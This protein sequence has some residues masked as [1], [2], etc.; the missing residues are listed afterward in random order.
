MKKYIL[1][2]LFI[3]L[4]AVTTNVYS[5]D[6]TPVQKAE[7]AL[8]QAK[9][10]EQNQNKAT[11][12]IDNPEKVNQWLDIGTN[13]G[14]ALSGTA[15]EMGIGINEFIQTPAGKVSLY[16]II[17]KVLGAE[18]ASILTVLFLWAMYI[19]FVHTH[20]NMKHPLICVYDKEKTNIFGNAK[21]INKYRK[22]S[23]HEDTTAMY[24]LGFIL[25]TAINVILI[26]TM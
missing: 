6:L 11:T 26:G 22:D 10:A 12:I 9:L 5:S 13:L 21:V 25:T 7:L 23:L 16:L 20:Y 17:W 3:I 8:Q 15:K 14:K 2:T 18:I 24:V 1:Q 4:F 19:Y